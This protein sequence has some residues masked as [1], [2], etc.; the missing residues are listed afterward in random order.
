[1]FICIKNDV[2]QQGRLM[3]ELAKMDKFVHTF[4]EPVLFV[5][6]QHTK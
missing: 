2:P 5:T 4:D 1:M 6:A 3:T